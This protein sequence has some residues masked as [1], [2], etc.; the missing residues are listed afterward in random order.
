MD[1]K[2][3]FNGTDVGEGWLIFDTPEAEIGV[4]LGSPR[5]CVSE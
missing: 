3:G 2:L 1:Y 5:L 4:H